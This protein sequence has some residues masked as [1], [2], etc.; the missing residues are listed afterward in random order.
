MQR[1]IAHVPDVMRLGALDVPSGFYFLRTRL[2]FSVAGRYFA[3][4]VRINS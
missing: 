3:I 4:Q 2:I 1:R